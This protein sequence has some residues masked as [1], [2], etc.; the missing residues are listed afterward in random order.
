MN[1][2]R[3]PDVIT[4]RFRYISVF[5]N[6]PGLCT[7]PDVEGVALTAAKRLIARAHCR[8][9]RLRIGDFYLKAGYVFTQT[10][11]PGTMLRRG[12]KVN[13]WV[14]NGRRPS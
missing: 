9:G 5:I 10:P 4:P 13:L 7:V 6:K 12:G 8:L 3:R 11:Q 2:D 14:S 1:G